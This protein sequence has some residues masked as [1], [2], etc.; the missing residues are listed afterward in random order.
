MF[1][2]P[3]HRNERP[4]PRVTVHHDGAGRGV[5]DAQE[6]GEDL[7]GRADVVLDFKVA[8]L[9]APRHE[10][11]GAVAR[12]VEEHSGAESPPIPISYVM[13]SRQDGS[14][15]TRLQRDSGAPQLAPTGSSPAHHTGIPASRGPAESCA[16]HPAPLAA[17]FGLGSEAVAEGRADEQRVRFSA[18]LA[19]DLAPDLSQR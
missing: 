14:L 2:S 19:A 18:P 3:R 13:L 7:I 11:L 12:L 17:D 16:D 9:V 5:D 8:A 4:Q 15:A 6:G 10:V 1:V